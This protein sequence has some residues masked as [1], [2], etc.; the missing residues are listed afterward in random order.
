MLMPARHLPI[1][2]ALVLAVLPAAEHP[3]AAGNTVPMV[4]HVSPTG[5]DEA[6]G[7]ADRPFA[8]LERA[9]DEARARRVADGPAQATP[10][11]V[12]AAGIHRR[13]ASLDLDKR[14][15]GLLIRGPRDRSARLHAGRPIDRGL[16]RPIADAALRD[17]LAEAARPHVVAIDLRAAGCP[18]TA[19]LPV[20]YNNGG[21]LPEL[22]W[23]SAPLP[24]ARWPNEGHALMEQ[25][26][27]RG[28]WT[29]PR[30]KRRGGTFIAAPDQTGD[31]RPR[32]W[33]IDEGVWLEGSW[34]VPWDPW[35]VR[36]AAIDPAA[37]SLTHAAAIGGGIGSKFA[38]KGSLG[39]G[40]EPWCAVNMLEEIDRPGEWSIHLPSQTLY[41]WPPA[42]SPLP[43]GGDG[44]GD[45]VIADRTASLIR[46]HDTRRV[47][48]QWLTIEGG[49]G[50]GIEVSGG[51]GGLIAGC[52]L[53]N[54]GGSG[55]VV[56]GGRRHVV[57]SSDFR[58]LGEA[59][60]ILVGGDR[61]TLDPCGHEAVN[62]D[63]S[64]VGR[65]RKTWAAAIHVG[66]PHGQFAAAAAVGCRVAH[67]F[68][69]DL[70]HAAVLY[71]GNDNLF[72]LND[73]RRVATASTDVG[74][75][76][77]RQDWTSRG[78][79]LRHNLVLDSPR[80]NAFYI[81]DGDS[82]DR[83]E[84]NIVVRAA[85]GPFIGGGHDNVVRHN[86]VVECLVGIHMDCRGI[87]RGYATN[88][89]YLRQLESVHPDEAPWRDR[90]P[91]MSRLRVNDPDSA[92]GA[93]RGNVIRENL[94]IG[95]GKGIQ[96][97]AKPQE[98]RD[99]TIEGNVDLSDADA[100]G[101]FVDASGGDFRLDRRSAAI[102]R[103][104]FFPDIPAA[105][106]GLEKD[107]YRPELSRGQ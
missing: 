9:R 103:V 54:L 45:L 20:A 27:D 6:D 40:K 57:R 21:G 22:F 101:P 24:L 104:P 78:N 12:L 3:V 4:W 75:F 68:L 90:Y 15:S 53:R 39:D 97:K 105:T 107:D 64:D 5:D 102:A 29:G 17:R 14:D 25:V 76:Y 1:A 80:A 42:G 48:I 92:V 61:S 28:E 94:T 79:L 77:T 87:A 62:N 13:T 82:G 36:V 52:L 55:V 10:T 50:H 18:P 59:G 95:C 69:H 31:W 81:D 91:G 51:E 67:N 11:I 32:H 7:T 60:I 26:L 47:R 98:F 43:D 35:V 72:E 56:T 66:T 89:S 58:T 33:P 86:V 84:E 23:N 70:P 44:P 63:V 93:A 46:L 96:L 2:V 100:P 88:P 19:A 38:A 74:A 85:C 99:N 49:L 73:I 71:G 83:V 34:R 30:E 41:L 106:I 16:L 8:T 37:R 65:R